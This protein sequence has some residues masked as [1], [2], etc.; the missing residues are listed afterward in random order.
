MLLRLSIRNGIM[1]SIHHSCTCI[2][3]SRNESV[4]GIWLDGYGRFLL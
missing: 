1:V 3:G 2:I 4:Q